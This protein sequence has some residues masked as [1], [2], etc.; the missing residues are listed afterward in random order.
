[1]STNAKKTINDE[2]EE[3]QKS[4]EDSQNEQSGKVSFT[5]RTIIYGIIGTI[6]ILISTKEASCPNDINVLLVIAMIMSFIYLLLD[7]SHYFIDSCRYRIESFR[8]DSANFDE[9]YK[10]NRC[11][12]NMDNIAVCSFM[13]VVFKYVLT[14]ITAILFL[15][16]LLKYFDKM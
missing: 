10:L 16:G 13:A 12:T 11:K 2:I 6:W 7:I 1:M 3:Y 4:C 14:L 8:L 9:N 5:S 15:L